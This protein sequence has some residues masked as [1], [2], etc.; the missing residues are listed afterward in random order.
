MLENF[1]L[2][3]MGGGTRRGPVSNRADAAAAI[4]EVI[5]FQ[6]LATATMVSDAALELSVEQL[7]GALN[8]K[9]FTEC[10][11]VQLAMP[12]TSRALAAVLTAEVRSHE[13][14]GDSR[15]LTICFT[16][17]RSRETS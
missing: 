13:P 8:K 16:G 15:M 3:N 2:L 6:T 9:L 4:G 11:R 17:R 14:K 7:I 1:P 5:R 10:A 12:P